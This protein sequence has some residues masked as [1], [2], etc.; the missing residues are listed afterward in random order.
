LV[1][2]NSDCEKMHG[3]YRIKYEYDL[4]FPKILNNFY[5]VI[6]RQ[7]WLAQTETDERS[8]VYELNRDI[9]RDRQRLMNS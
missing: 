8:V 1:S 2:V 6:V 5:F 3:D 9:K 7:L 4:L